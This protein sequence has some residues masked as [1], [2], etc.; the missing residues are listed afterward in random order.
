MAAARSTLRPRIAD[1]QLVQPALGEDALVACRRRP[2][3]GPLRPQRAARHAAAVRQ[4]RDRDKRL[5]EARHAREQPIGAV[6]QVVI[7]ADAALVLVDALV[8]DPPIV[9][10]GSAAGRQ[11]IPLEQAPGHRIDPRVGD[12]IAGERGARRPAAGARRRRRVVDHRHPPADRLGEDAL[13]LERGRHRRDHRPADRLALALI[14]GEEERRA[15]PDRPAGHAAELVSSEPRRGRGARREEVAGV[16]VLVTRELEQAAVQV[17]LAGLRRQVDDAAVEAAELGRRAVALDR[18]LLDGVDVGEERDLA[19]LRLEHRDAVEEIFVGARAPAVDP[20]QRGRGRRR[21]G[22]TRSQAGQRD[23]AAAVE[24]QIDDA[25]LVDHV[26]EAGGLAAQQ[27]RRA[28]YGHRL[29]PPADAERDVDAQRLAR[30]QRDAFA[31]RWPE[32]RELDAD[33][34]AARRQAGHHVA[35]VGVRG[36]RARH[37]RRGRGRGDRRARRNRAGLVDDVAD[38]RAARDLRGR[39]R[40]RREPRQHHCPHGRTRTTPTVEHS[41]SR[42]LDGRSASTVRQIGSNRSEACR[43]TNGLGEGLRS[44]RSGSLA[45]CAAASDA[46]A[47]PRCPRRARRAGATRRNSRRRCAGCRA[48]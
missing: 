47:G 14:I 40:R 27:R 28:G 35:P 31:D 23:E 21:D 41:T 22:D 4:G 43:S 39:H 16:E 18:E 25:P 33:R 38:Q 11:R 46:G 3:A 10:R 8:A 34:V 20:R 17:V 29:G 32:P 15:L 13:A 24:R 9:V 2:G 30:L 44:R 37:A 45:P 6:A 12:R 7:D 1:P 19:R 26:A 36:R 42:N 48:R 5:A